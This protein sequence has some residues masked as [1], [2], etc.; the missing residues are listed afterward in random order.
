MATIKLSTLVLK[1][2]AAAVRLSDGTT[3]DAGQYVTQIHC[4]YHAADTDGTGTAISG[5][6][7]L[8]EP[9]SRSSDDF[10][11]YVALTRD[12]AV[13]IAEQWRTDNNVDA[14]LTARLASMAA[15]DQSVQ[16]PPWET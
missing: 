12:W 9:S 11:A 4:Q 1:V 13:A 6:I 10:V 8:A 15:V 16:T 3:V 5:R 14:T 2:N 7:Q